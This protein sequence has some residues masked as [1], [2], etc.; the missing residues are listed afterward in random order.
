MPFSFWVFSHA[1]IYLAAPIVISSIYCIHRY[2]VVDYLFATD[3]A[4]VTT[5]PITSSICQATL[6]Y[7]FLAW[8]QIL[9][10]TSYMTFSHVLFLGSF[11]ICVYNFYGK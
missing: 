5:S 3:A 10:Y 2:F 11:F 6:F 8:I 7:V 9:P 4:Q 1:A